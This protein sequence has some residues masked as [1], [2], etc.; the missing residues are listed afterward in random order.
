MMRG[1]IA[2]TN[3]DR[4]SAEIKYCYRNRRDPMPWMADA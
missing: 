2:V 3:I 1:E 4:S